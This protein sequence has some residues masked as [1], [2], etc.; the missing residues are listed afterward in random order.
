MSYNWSE[1]PYYD[2]L[3]GI[4]KEEEELTE[5]ELRRLELEKLGLSAVPEEESQEEKISEEE[6]EHAP[7]I[8]D[9]EDQEDEEIIEDNI[10]TRSSYYNQ[11]KKEPS[12]LE[13]KQLSY[14]GEAD[15]I[16][17]YY[18]ED[19][20]NYVTV[21]T[22][23]YQLDDDKIAN[24]PA[25]L[26]NG[27]LVSDLNPRTEKALYNYW[28]KNDPSKIEYFKTEQEAE[29]SAKLKSQRHDKIGKEKGIIVEG[30]E[31]T[32]TEAFEFGAKLE[33]HTIGNIAR[34]LK[35]GVRSITND[36]EFTTAIK[37]IEKERQEVIFKELKEK[38]GKEF[39]GREDEGAVLAGRIATA[40]ADPVTFLLPWAKAAKLGK[41]AATGFGA[42]VGVTDMAIY[43]YAAYGHVT[44]TSLL[45]AG[46]IGGA[47]KVGMIT[48]LDQ[49]NENKRI[50]K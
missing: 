18:D 39:E 35:A 8:G 38:Y 23:G 34:L 49:Y 1:S 36:V 12:E 33:R 37:N 30:E 5:E 19:T 6:I 31:L 50:I 16:P 11:I 45:F 22:R 10:W 42:G 25:L 14:K 20:K 13:G 47:T 46:T 21:H 9:E 27:K 2:E 26:P 15:G 44:P 7:V 3:I 4:E 41:I 29:L 17:F 48:N 32:G 24:F 40:F 43:E 28:L